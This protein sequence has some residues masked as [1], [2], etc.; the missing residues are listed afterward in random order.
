MYRSDCGRM[1]QHIAAFSSEIPNQG[2]QG[3]LLFSKCHSLIEGYRSTSGRRVRGHCP[4]WLS[5]LTKRRDNALIFP[6]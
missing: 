6:M 2:G 3:P 5:Y 4:P 1:T